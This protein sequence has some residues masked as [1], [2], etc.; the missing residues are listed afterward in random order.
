M[1][2][3]SEVQTYV[4]AR[5]TGFIT[6]FFGKT[7]QSIVQNPFR[8]FLH[9]RVREKKKLK[10]FVT[11][12][13]HARYFEVQ[14]GFVLYLFPPK[15]NENFWDFD[16]VS[17]KNPQGH[18]IDLLYPEFFVASYKSRRVAVENFVKIYFKRGLA[19]YACNSIF[20]LKL[21]GC[22]HHCVTYEYFLLL[23]GQDLK[24]VYCS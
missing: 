24:R 20:F 11:F 9:K 18:I 3:G 19:N 7:F 2:A 6:N 21:T 8:S 16:A 22:W 17:H 23:E 15:I 4:R 12:L 13:H 5:Q 14:S 1:N 10:Y